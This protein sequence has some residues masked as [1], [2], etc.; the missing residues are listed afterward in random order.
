MARRRDDIVKWAEINWIRHAQD[1]SRWKSLRTAYTQQ[2]V[3]MGTY[4]D[5]YTKIYS[6]SKNFCADKFLRR[7][8]FFPLVTIKCDIFF[9]AGWNK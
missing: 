6:L 1:R 9:F 5:V 2:W 7:Y 8:A 4:R 3:D